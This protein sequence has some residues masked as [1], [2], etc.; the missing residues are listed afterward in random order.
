MDRIL[1]VK[2]QQEAKVKIIKQIQRGVRIGSRKSS[3]WRWPTPAAGS[4]GHLWLLGT[5]NTACVIEMRWVWIPGCDGRESK[6]AR[7]HF[8]LSACSDDGISGVLA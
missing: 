3:M 4:I 1:L 6:V 8:V 5:R 7:V 2:K